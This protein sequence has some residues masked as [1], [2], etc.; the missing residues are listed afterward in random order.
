MSKRKKNDGNRLEELN[1]KLVAL[2]M[3]QEEAIEKLLK[4]F[5]EKESKLLEEIQSLNNKVNHEIS[6]NNI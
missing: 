6:N 2:H 4:R 5:N 1:S 3:E